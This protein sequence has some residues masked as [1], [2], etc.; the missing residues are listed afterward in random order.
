MTNNQSLIKY[1]YLSIFASLAVILLKITA[2]LITQ[3]I[4]FLSDAM[5]SLVNLTSAIIAYLMI[6]LS[7]K[8][9]DKNHPYGHTKAEYFSSL[10]E[11]S[12][13]FL[14]AFLIII[15]SIKRIISPVV[16]KQISL[17]IFVSLLAT[18]VNFFAASKLISVGK[19]YRSITLEADG[20]HLLTDV[21]TSMGVILAVFLVKITNLLIIDPLIAI[22]VALNI[23]IT[24]L[25]LI[26]RSISGFLDEAFEKKDLEIINNVFKKYQIKGL[27]FHS[28]K[29]R[30]SGHKKFLSFHV[31]FPNRWS[32]KKSH[33]L[34]YQ[35]EKE[36]KDYFPQI[37]IES[38]LEPLKD[39]KSFED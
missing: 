15:T 8:P 38:H 26:K 19:K 11:A 22:A 27:K 39:K 34:V 18:A 1:T 2:Y 36:I 17:G 29:S 10:F 30:Q 25:N 6:K 37:E 31:L 14:A 16:L 35:V 9:A 20:Y 33:D 4:G 5:E 28:I 12:M 32:I 3:S 24:A 21:Y 23:L 13:I 7:E